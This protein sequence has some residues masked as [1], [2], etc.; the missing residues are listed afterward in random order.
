MRFPLKLAIFDGKTGEQKS[1]KLIIGPTVPEDSLLVSKNYSTATVINNIFGTDTVQV[2]EKGTPN[3]NA[4]NDSFIIDSFKAKPTQDGWLVSMN[5]FNKRY[6]DAVLE[7]IDSKGNL[8][9]N[10][11]PRIIVGNRTPNNPLIAFKDDF[12]AIFSDCWDKYEAA[13]VYLR[14]PLKLLKL[15]A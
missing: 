6:S 15:F 5:V 12:I 4:M 8:V 2:N 1:Y 11:L 3:I 10:Q 9:L 7:V 13:I 14:E